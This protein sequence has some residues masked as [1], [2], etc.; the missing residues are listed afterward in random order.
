M[1]CV[2]DPQ[3]HSLA[4]PPTQ[5]V[6]HGQGHSHRRRGGGAASHQARTLLL[7]TQPERALG[8]RCDRGGLDLEPWGPG[9]Q[10][11]GARPSLHCVPRAPCHHAQVPWNPG[12]CQGGPHPSP[13]S[14]SVESHRCPSL[15]PAFPPPFSQLILSQEVSSVN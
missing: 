15:T 8:S 5:E 10:L 3:T 11:L 4:Q 9:L 7:E 13:R 2:C 12:S 14:T 1:A 6:L